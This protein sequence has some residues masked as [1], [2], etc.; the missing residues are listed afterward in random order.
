MDRHHHHHDKRQTTYHQPFSGFHFFP[1]GIQG[2]FVFL[3]FKRVV[4]VLP[5]WLPA[6]AFLPPFPLP[7]VFFGVPLLLLLLLEV[8]GVLETP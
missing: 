7:V 6:L 1:V 5:W 2:I 3:L 4:I 8:V